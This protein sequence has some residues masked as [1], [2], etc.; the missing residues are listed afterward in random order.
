MAYYISYG[1]FQQALSKHVKKTGM[2]YSV[3]AMAKKLQ[4]KGAFLSD[5]PVVSHVSQSIDI[6]TMP[7]EEFQAIIDSQYI[8]FQ[9][10]LDSGVISEILEDD[11]IPAARDAFVIRSFR[12][13]KH[14][15]HSHNF[16]E[17][18]YCLQGEAEFYFEDDFRIM[19]ASELCIIAPGSSHD[20]IINNDDTIVYTLCL[21]A[22][23]FNNSFFS[24]MSR[25]DLLSYFFRTIL[26]GDKH[27]NY[28][29]FYTK[30]KNALNNC[31]R[32]LILESHRHDQYYNTCSVSYVNIMFATLLR[33]YSETVQFYNYKLGTDFS[34]VLQYIQSNYQTLT[35]SSLA[36]LFHYSEPHLCTLIHQNTG[37][38]FTSLIKQLRLAEATDYLIHSDMKI[39]EIAERVGYN[40]ADHFSRVFRSV[41]SVSPVEYRKQHA[42]EFEPISPFYEA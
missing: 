17:I 31:F 4:E 15:S 33:T 39:T 23:T 34:L 30:E 42:V 3:P 35:L 20:V 21:R 29:L 28:L 14:K 36:E 32:N 5:Q 18:N 26:Q 25:K 2:A 7:E 19:K 27:P 9:P 38:T 24:L 37:M 8:N 11:L 13:T 10:I 12:H 1:E 40:S 22:S 6:S 41:H 16:F